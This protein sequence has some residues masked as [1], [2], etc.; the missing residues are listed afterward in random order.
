MPVLAQKIIQE[1]AA[2]RPL[3]IEPFRVSHDDINSHLLPPSRGS[4]EAAG[5]S[6]DLTR[7]RVEG[8]FQHAGTK[9]AQAFVLAC[10]WCRTAKILHS[11]GVFLKKEATIK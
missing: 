3:S 10:V 2:V 6:I 7:A 11:R 1:Q 9:E 4:T 8:A 5:R